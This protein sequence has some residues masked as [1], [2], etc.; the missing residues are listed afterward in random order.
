MTAT[1]ATRTATTWRDVVRIGAG[2]VM[3]ILG[4]VGLVLPVLQGVLFL[5]VAAALLA[6]Y[7]RSVRRMMA[8]GRLRFPNAYHRAQSLKRR[9]TRRR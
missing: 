6:P 9:L 4:L 3:L 7:S 1:R 2:I 5:L 8:W